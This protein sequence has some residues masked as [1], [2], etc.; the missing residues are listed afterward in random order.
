M[1]AI[2]PTRD[3][4]SKRFPVASFALR[5]PPGHPFEIAYA[6]DARLLCGDRSGARR[7]SN[8]FSTR[9]RGWLIAPHGSAHYMLPDDVLDAFAGA[10]RLYYLLASYDS[11]RAE[12]GLFSVSP[13]ALAATPYVRLAGDLVLRRARRAPVRSPAPRALA[14]GGDGL[15]ASRA[16]M[17]D[18]GDFS[19]DD[20][21]HEGGGGPATP[22]AKLAD[23]QVVRVEVRDGSGAVARFT[24][25]YPIDPNGNMRIPS[26]GNVVARELTLVA[27]RE[28]LRQAFTNVVAGSS[29]N[30]TPSASIMTYDAPIA[31]AD[32]L[33]LRILDPQGNVDAS[34]G[35]YVVDSDGKLHLPRVG[36]IDTAD[37]T[38][39]ALEA[40]L[41][42][43]VGD[44]FLRGAV[45]NVSKTELA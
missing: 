43:A 44:R 39:G 17:D 14:W 13:R 32:R 41:E 7:E 20:G 8:F 35:S 18:N 22:D 34:S 29:V 15:F 40:G 27:L 25:E 3:L 1:L 10:Q 33:Y 16:L 38:M 24:H 2:T 26:L 6:T 19:V 21:D 28:S 36:D 37:M 23:G 31:R 45:V 4:V 9:S 42:R 12:R 30:V 5:V 11:M